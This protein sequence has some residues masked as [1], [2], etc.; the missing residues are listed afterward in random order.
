MSKK[1][2]IKKI[3]IGT[4]ILAVVGGGA[5]YFLSQKQSMPS[6]TE[7]E[8]TT[9]NPTT[10]T[11]TQSISGTAA[12]EAADS[13]TITPLVEVEIL[14]SYFE[15]GDVVEKDMILYELDSSD[16]Q[17]TIETN[18][19]SLSA[20]Q[21]SYQNALEDLYDLTVTA[22]ASGSLVSLDV[23][24]GD[25][26]NAN[27]VIGTIR[28]DAVMT[29]EMTF[30]ADDADTF[31]VGMS[32]NVT[33]DGS[34]ETVQGTVTNI[35]QTTTIGV[36]NMVQKLVEISVNNPGGINFGQVATADINGV[37]SS[38]SGTFDYNAERD[39]YANVSGTVSY[40]AVNEGDMLS[41][42]NTILT[43]TSDQ[44]QDSAQSQYENLQKS[45]INMENAQQTLEK[46]IITS[47]ITGT[48]VEK[49]YKT[50]ETTEQGSPLAVIYDLSYLSL[51]LNID[52]LDISDLAVGQ[53]VTV[54]SEAL[55]GATYD[56]IITKVSVVGQTNSGVTTYPVT[57]EINAPDGLLPGMNVDAEIV[58]ESAEDALTIPVT[59]LERNNLVLITAD[60]P[61]AK[62]AVENEAPE[63]YVYVKVET[64]LATNDSVQI[65]SGL[66]A[67]DTIAYRQAMASGT[68]EMEGMM[69]PGMTGGM[70]TGGE[71]PTSGGMSG[72]GGPR[73]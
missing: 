49:N 69:M 50:G 14:S 8:Y 45:Q 26:I 17:S 30:P 66:T 4:V 70:P 11:L 38:A 20:S 55:E 43:L 71:M 24:V 12:L 62:N 56:G 42:G 41:V 15:E 29:I 39:I 7:I 64:G 25:D 18:T 13:Y 21:R 54:T 65:I 9:E 53:A 68:E 59:A 57:V 36:G 67:E 73:G 27:Q 51:T 22:E 5:Y 44:L 16:A 3:V 58:L 46:Y 61:S 28:D 1:F 52:E 32:A 37:Y 34:F 19:I 10:Q 60:S 33:L 6:A 47:P 31:S 40:I 35:S 72:G 2:P 48:V 63:G 23:E